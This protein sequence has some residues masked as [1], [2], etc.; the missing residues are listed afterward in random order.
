MLDH[1]A[2]PSLSARIARAA[3]SPAARTAY[4]VLGSVGLAALAVAVVG[5]K[6][7]NQQVLKPIGGAVGDQAEKLWDESRGLRRQV[8][9]L[10]E[11]ASSPA[12]R[13]KLVRN[14]QSWAGHFRAT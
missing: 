6:R 9:G 10:F 5:P 1:P 8:A 4:I 14:F 11:R 7:I 3:A 13:E 12:G 2:P